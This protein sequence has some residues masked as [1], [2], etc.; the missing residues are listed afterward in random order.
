[1]TRIP[2]NEGRTVWMSNERCPDCDTHL[3]T[4]GDVYYC[5]GQARLIEAEELD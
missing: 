2:Y 3:T 4:D 1:M 5:N